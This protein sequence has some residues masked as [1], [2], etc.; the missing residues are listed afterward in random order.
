MRVSTV[1]PYRGA[2]ESK[3][4]NDTN[5]ET[6][7]RHRNL[8]LL[9][10]SV[11]L[12]SLVSYLYV[13]RLTRQKLDYISK[14]HDSVMHYTLRKKGAKRVLKCP[15]GRTHAIEPLNMVP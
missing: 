12:V 11:T 8:Y 1:N 6:T 15:V 10:T 14:Y 7:M 9:L 4:E 2:C 13:V 5:I 3:R